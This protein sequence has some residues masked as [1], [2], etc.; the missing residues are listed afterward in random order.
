MLLKLP[1]KA[2]EIYAFKSLHNSNQLCILFGDDYIYSTLV[3][4][5]CLIF[6]RNIDCII[7]NI[8]GCD[9]KNILNIDS[10]ASYNDISIDEIERKNIDEYENIVIVDCF[11]NLCIEKYV[12]SNKLTFILTVHEYMYSYDLISFYVPKFKHAYIL[13]EQDQYNWM[14][15]NGISFDDII[16]T[17]TEL[18][19]PRLFIGRLVIE[20]DKI[21]RKYA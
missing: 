11:T 8:D 6:E 3:E 12:Q 9:Y 13:A 4:S 18:D 19:V 10:G 20:V 21:C 15:E 1:I 17:K 2:K 14:K 7:I 16:R 5:A